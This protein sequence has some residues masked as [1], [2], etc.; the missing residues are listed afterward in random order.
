MIA[1]LLL[2]GGMLVTQDGRRRVDLLA[3]DGRI[4]AIGKN[5]EPPADSVRLDVDGLCV[6]PGVIDPH[7]HFWEDGFTAAPDFRDGSLSAVCGGITTIIDMPLTEPCVLDPATLRDKIV[8]GERTSRVDFAL[9]G[10][11]SP[12]NGDQLEPM[13]NAG[14]AGLKIFTCTTGCAMEGITRDTDLRATLG[15]IAEFGGLACL[16][17]EDEDRLIANRAAQLEAG[18]TD[19]AGFLAWHDEA[20]ELLAL[21][22]ILG[23][24]KAVGATVNIV[25]VT[26]S[27]GLQLVAAARHDGVAATAE[28]CPHY[29]H[30]GSEDILAQG[31]RAACA[32]PVRPRRQITA[33][34]AAIA[35]GSVHTIGTDHC[36]VSLERKRPPAIDA[37]PGLPGLETMVPLLLDLV[38]RGALTLEHLV[39][40]TSYNTARLYGLYPRKGSVGIG[41]DADFTIV[42]PDAVWTLAA[43]RLVGSAGWTPFEGITVQGRVEMTIIRGRLVARDGHAVDAAGP[44]AF[45]PRQQ[46]PNAQF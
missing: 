37:Q 34:R 21:R 20:A 26:S 35:D 42:D 41:A 24:A 17:S 18:R 7:T 6:L 29:L 43:D 40:V 8:L 1:P 14:V 12:T 39:E 22:R 28:T 19:E 3:L 13:W 46:Q 38:A 33:M 10:G 15:R 32:P 2:R 27:A 25:H 9:F 23:H 4:A 31:S 5:L 44:A 45:I 11:A 16:H 30:L 36:A